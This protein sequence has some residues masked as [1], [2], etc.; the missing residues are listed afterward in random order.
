M[1]IY[2]TKY[3][4]VEVP[5]YEVE[6]E[7]EAED[8]LSEIDCDDLLEHMVNNCDAEIIIRASLALTANGFST[9]TGFL[10]VSARI[11]FS[12]WAECGVAT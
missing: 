7:I 12:A 10:A 1:S 5:D 9:R 8:V 6:I 2:L 11:A 4:H 3:V